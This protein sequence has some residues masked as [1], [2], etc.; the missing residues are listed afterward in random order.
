MRLIPVRWRT[1]RSANRNMWPRIRAVRTQHCAQWYHAAV[2]HGAQWNLTPHSGTH[3]AQ[4]YHTCAQRYHTAPSGI[5]RPTVAS[6]G[7]QWYHT[8]HNCITGIT[9]CTLV[10]HG[11]QWYQAT[12]SGIT[13]RTVVS[14]GAQWHHTAQSGII[15][16]R[17][18]SYSAHGIIMPM[19]DAQ[20]AQLSPTG[21]LN[22]TRITTS[23]RCALIF[24][25]CIRVHTINNSLNARRRRRLWVGAAQCS[26]LKRAQTEHKVH[27]SKLDTH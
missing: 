2:S 21:L 5:T 4:W 7:A 13:R 14:H 1:I 26:L 17:V 27:C 11:A 19:E 9:R 25:P 8:A 6:H 3:G 16:R 10:S 24:A 18:V 20:C 12:H 15:Q 23:S 22:H